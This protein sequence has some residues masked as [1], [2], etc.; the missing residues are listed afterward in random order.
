M[1]IAR[2]RLVDLTSRMDSNGRWQWDVPAGQ[3]TVLRLGH[4]STGVQECPGAGDRAG[5]GMRQAEQGKGI[6]ANF[7]GHDGQAGG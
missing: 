4:T 2:D 6:E 5:A 3:W 7:A 1:V